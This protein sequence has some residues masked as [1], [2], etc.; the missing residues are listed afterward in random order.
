MGEDYRGHELTRRIGDFGFGEVHP[1]ALYRT[2]GRME[3][4]DLV[5]SERDGLDHGPTRRWYSITAPGESYLESW[6]D[7]LAR[8]QEE[9]GLFFALYE[10][11]AGGAAGCAVEGRILRGAENAG[12]SEKLG[13]LGEET[14]SDRA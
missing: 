12:G 2:L 4:E 11:A 13:V 1:R 5:V 6:S 14:R 3:R 9:I 8:Y 7:S 10:G